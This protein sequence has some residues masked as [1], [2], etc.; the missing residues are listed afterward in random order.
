MTMPTNCLMVNRYD[1]AMLCEPGGLAECF[2]VAELLGQ[3]API[4]DWP[5]ASCW[6]PVVGTI[7]FEVFQG[8]LSASA[9]QRPG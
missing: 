4:R 2:G 8:V 3:T 6:V 9:S 5:A 1:F 7:S